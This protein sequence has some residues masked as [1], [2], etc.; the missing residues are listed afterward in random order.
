MRGVHSA[1]SWRSLAIVFSVWALIA[2]G[3]CAAVCGSRHCEGPEDNVESLAL[4][5][6]SH[7]DQ[8]EP[9]ASEHAV[10]RG[11][12]SAESTHEVAICRCDEVASHL[13]KAADTGTTISLDTFVVA[14]P[15]PS[16]AAV[17]LPRDVSDLPV[18]PFPSTNPPLL[19]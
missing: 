18:H 4:H 15:A 14:L 9:C 6:S 2:P 8:T 19:I 10:D 5:G 11:V 3:V 13:P 12:A 17:H 7:R 16:P 1:V